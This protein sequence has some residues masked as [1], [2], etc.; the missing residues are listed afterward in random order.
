MSGYEFRVGEAIASAPLIVG[1]PEFDA[2]HVLLPE[3]YRNEFQEGGA[4]PETM[5]V[6]PSRETV[7]PANQIEVRDSA[8][9]ATLY[10]E[11]CHQTDGP[12]PAEQAWNVYHTEG[13]AVP[14]RQLDG[15]AGFALSCF[16]D[17]TTPTQ[18]QHALKVVPHG[19]SVTRYTLA[20]FYR[21]EPPRVL[22]TTDEHFIGLLGFRA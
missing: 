12:D 16:R 1:N 21:T 13:H 22:D 4:P 11:Y 15:V 14:V 7:L 9:L 5:F 18:V 8:E 20:E 2:S 6:F 17:S 3:L 10:R 19:L